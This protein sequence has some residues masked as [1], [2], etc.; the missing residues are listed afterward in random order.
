[1]N[2]DP[3]WRLYYP[4][5]K[6]KPAQPVE[7]YSI[8]IWTPADLPVFTDLALETCAAQ[9][10]AHLTDVLVLP[11]SRDQTFCSQFQRYKD[12]HPD[13]PIRLVLPTLF[14]HCI[15]K[16]LNNGSHNTWFQ[17][18]A[19]FEACRSKYAMLH[20]VD[21]FVFDPSLFK[22][23]Y[24]AC[25]SQ[26]RAC[27]GVSPVWDN[28]YRENGYGHVCA[29]WELMFNMDWVRQFP[30]QDHHGHFG[31]VHGKQHQFDSML[32]PQCLTPP[33]KIQRHDVEEQ[34]V[35]FNF[36]TGTYRRFQNSKGPFEDSG[37]RILFIRM[38]HE[39]FPD[40]AAPAGLPTLDELEK[41]LTDATHPV[42]YRSHE[43]AETYAT[44][45]SKLQDLIDNVT[46]SQ[47]LRTAFARGTKAFDKAFHWMGQAVACY[48]CV[49]EPLAPLV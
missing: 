5:W 18:M 11:D 26:N 49:L 34:F 32:K 37:F 44:F 47:R 20:D 4:T 6:S 25:A 41:G 19:G 43:A 27:L 29:T 9:D 12:R 21:A 17:L 38:L 36:V 31:S 40:A 30:P 39:G 1:M 14:Q 35:H 33:E 7:G 22:K 15:A 16:T 2:M 13:M 42:T 10:H 23:H 46:L 8:L 24:E 45:R 48:Y 28:W 3:L